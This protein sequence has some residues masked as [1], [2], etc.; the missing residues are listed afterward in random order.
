[1]FQQ[2]RR[3]EAV[4]FKIKDVSLDCNGYQLKDE[5]LVHELMVLMPCLTLD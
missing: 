1:M 3:I 2:M 5:H 4:D